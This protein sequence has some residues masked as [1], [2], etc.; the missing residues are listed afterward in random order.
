MC[1]SVSYEYSTKETSLP[2]PSSNHFDSSAF[3]NKIHPPSPHLC[4]VDLVE[5]V[6]FF[7]ASPHEIK[8]SSSSPCTWARPRR[9]TT[10]G[11]SRTHLWN[12]DVQSGRGEGE[13]SPGSSFSVLTSS[14]AVVQHGSVLMTWKVGIESA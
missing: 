3:E 8:P 6:V 4:R 7:F 2:S 1:M 10:E 13:P 11:D 5:E 12:D 14:T 9:M